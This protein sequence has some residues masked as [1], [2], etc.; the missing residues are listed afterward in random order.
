MWLF[1]LC[2]L[3]TIHLIIQVVNTHFWVNS[4]KLFNILI[5]AQGLLE[6]PLPILRADR[7]G[8]GAFTS[9]ITLSLPRFLK[10]LF[11]SFDWIWSL[12]NIVE[13]VWRAMINRSQFEL[14]FCYLLLHRLLIYWYLAMN[15]ILLVFAFIND[16]RKFIWQI[17]KFSR[18]LKLLPLFIRILKVKLVF[19]PVFIIIDRLVKY[20]AYRIPLRLLNVFCIIILACFKILK[21][22]WTLSV[23]N[24]TDLANRLMSIL[25]NFAFLLVIKLYL[26]LFLP[27]TLKHLH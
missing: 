21:M 10:F 7:W 9:S 11:V 16:S 1:W 6:V 15:L 3:K 13:N 27:L 25:I 2:L 26:N 23:I 14:E 4:N 5:R 19:L 24:R 22:K 8:F 12:A 20:W 17:F 18:F